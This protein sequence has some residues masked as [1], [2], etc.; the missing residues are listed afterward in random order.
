MTTN[1]LAP[2]QPNEIKV[3]YECNGEQIALSPNIIRKYLVNGGGTVSDQEVMMFLN[4]CKFQHL[5]PFLRE[6]YLIKYGNTTP[7]TM[8]VG[9]DV[10]FK[11]AYR[12]K[13]YAGFEAGVWVLSEKGLEQRT[14][15]LVLSN[16]TIVGGWAKVYIKGY[17]VPVE[18]SVSFDEYKGTKSDGSLNSQW[19]KKPATM[20][21]KVAIVQALREAFPDEFEGMY[22]PEEIGIDE[23]ELATGSVEMETIVEPPAPIVNDNDD[24]FFG[25]VQ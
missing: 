17:T 5:N 25:G 20:I 15:S 9:K 14:G 12:N 18:A 19:S 11:R 24:D 2:T 1:S 22:T 4:L 10:Y 6:A 16:E 7:A 3:K 23:T 21:R 8:V 13:N